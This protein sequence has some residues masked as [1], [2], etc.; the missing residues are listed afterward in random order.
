MK[1]LFS[2]IGIEDA[3]D[4]FSWRNCTNATVRVRLSNLNEV[5]NQIAHGR[6]DITV[7]GRNFT[8]TL[9]AARGFRGF[10]EAFGSAHD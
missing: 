3:L 6:R 4:G 8:L 2:R 5:C 7:D 1:A 9:V 10:A